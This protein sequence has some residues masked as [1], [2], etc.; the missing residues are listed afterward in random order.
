MLLG[1]WTMGA[2]SN[3]MY[4]RHWLTYLA[5]R[6]E[7][8]SKPRGICYVVQCLHG[9]CFHAHMAKGA[10]GGGGSSDR[11]FIHAYYSEK[12]AASSTTSQCVI[13]IMLCLT[14]LA[15]EI[16]VH[17]WLDVWY[18]FGN[19]HCIWMSRQLGLCVASAAV[20]ARILLPPD[21]PDS[22]MMIM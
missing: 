21:P 9:F 6:I 7:R 10:R 5:Y 15:S 11:L 4:T 12:S 16:S 13:I 19:T 22:L 18:E 1:H 3:K 8:L 14:A 17:Y 2:P 20:L